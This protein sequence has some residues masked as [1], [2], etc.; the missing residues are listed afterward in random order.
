MSDRS[1][2]SPLDER[3]LARFAFGLL[4]CLRPTTDQL[5]WLSHPILIE[6]FLNRRQLVDGLDQRGLGD[7]RIV[8]AHVVGGVAE[9]RAAAVAGHVRGKTDGKVL[10]LPEAPKAW[11]V[12]CKSMKDEYWKVKK[13]GVRKGYFT[14]WVQLNTY[15]HLFGFE[16][17]L[18][19]CRNKNTG[20]VYSERIETDHAEAIRLLMRAERI[21]K[22][23]NPPPRLH[24]EPQKKP[25][26]RCRRPWATRPLRDPPTP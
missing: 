25:E 13:E 6:P 19:I 17:G 8:A 14:H 10:G 4:Q 11:H 7:V 1:P 24:E 12:E 21:V 9:Y 22:Y 3:L 2:C 26:R 5:H 18:Y 20:E 23:A 16:R 15:C